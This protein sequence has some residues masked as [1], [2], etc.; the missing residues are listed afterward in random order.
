MCD[1]YDDER[2]R[3]F[4]RELD[5]RKELAKPQPVDDELEGVA[6]SLPALVEPKR[7]KPRGL[8]R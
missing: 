3:A 2:M 5:V 7:S 8:P 1:E 4:W 6:L